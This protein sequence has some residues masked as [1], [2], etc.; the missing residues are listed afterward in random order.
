MKLRRYIFLFCIAAGFAG[1]SDWKATPEQYLEWLGENRSDFIIRSE[2]MDYRMDAQYYP[3]KFYEA[4]SL[5]KGNETDS[6]QYL[7]SFYTFKIKLTN[8]EGTQPILRAGNVGRTEYMTRLSYLDF[9]AKDDLELITGLD[10]LP[11]ISYHFERTYDM[12]PYNA[13]SI[14]FKK[15]KTEKKAD[16]VR[17]VFNEKVF[18]I[19]NVNFIF[20]SE[21]FNKANNVKLIHQ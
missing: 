16:N 18:G 9:H 11:C 1:C 8:R 5:L 12:V 2:F 19:G 6:F 3:P 7:D 4:K 20:P 15:A 17:L 21:T 10:T 13:I 14:A